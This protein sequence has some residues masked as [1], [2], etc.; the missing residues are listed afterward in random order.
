MRTTIL[1]LAAATLLAAGCE[2]RPVDRPPLA[3]AAP[4][5]AVESVDVFR[6]ALDPPV[7]ALD[8]AGEPRTWNEAYMVRLALETSN[9]PIAPL[10]GIYVGDYLVSETGSWEAGLYFYVH[11]PDLLARIDGGELFYQ[12]DDGE[13]RKLGARLD[14][15]KAD[16]LRLV[17]EGEL[18]PKRRQ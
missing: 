8:L 15:G 18:F 17:P 4:S 3:S 16:E 10:L 14:V 1:L 7:R 12:I 13:R 2:P 9:V 11:D 5:V 6:V